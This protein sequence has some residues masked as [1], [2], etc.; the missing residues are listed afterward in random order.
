MRQIGA[1]RK[2]VIRLT[3]A[4]ENV[5]TNVYAYISFPTFAHQLVRN[6]K[7]GNFT[8]YGRTQFKVYAHVCAGETLEYYPFSR[9]QYDRISP[10]ILA[11][12]KGDAMY[13]RT[14]TSNQDHILSYVCTLYV[15]VYRTRP[16]NDVFTSQVSCD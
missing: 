10:R 6:G 2:K 12:L 13:T 16:G 4:S 3:S 7:R 14:H 11:P 1:Q 8:G 5:Y 9:S 15:R